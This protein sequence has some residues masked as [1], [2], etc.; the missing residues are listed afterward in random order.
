MI[1]ELLTPEQLADDLDMTV[2]A[3]AQWRYRG[4][5]PRFVTEAAGSATAAP[6]SRSG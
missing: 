5:G 3:L 2:T 1:E 6:T 4:M